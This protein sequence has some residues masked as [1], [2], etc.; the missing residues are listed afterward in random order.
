MIADTYNVRLFARFRELAGRDSVTILLQP[1][2]TVRD[3]RSA[4]LDVWPKSEAL[5]RAS[6]L[7]IDGEYRDD[8]YAISPN[9]EIALIPP[10]SGG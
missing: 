10:V 4:L 6:T 7:A 9:D 5:L 2:A 1:S 3:L 8:D